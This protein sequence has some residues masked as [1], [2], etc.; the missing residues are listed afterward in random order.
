MFKYEQSSSYDE[1]K[2]GGHNPVQ[3]SWELEC[4]CPFVAVPLAQELTLDQA[5][6]YADLQFLIYKEGV[7]MSF[8]GGEKEEEE[9]SRRLN[10]MFMKYAEISI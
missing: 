6:H 7:I 1:L 9:D 3:Q 8:P 2:P 5:L 10:S 4:L